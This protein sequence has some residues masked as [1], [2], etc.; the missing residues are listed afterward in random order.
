MYYLYYSGMSSTGPVYFSYVP[1][2]GPK[3]TKEFILG[4]SARSGGV[5]RVFFQCAIWGA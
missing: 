2:A 3:E 5:A 1:Y 4:T